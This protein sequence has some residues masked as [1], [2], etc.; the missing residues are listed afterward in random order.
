[1][2]DIEDML[3]STV[4]YIVIFTSP[5]H[6]YRANLVDCKSISQVRALLMAAFHQMW[7]DA[8]SPIDPDH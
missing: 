5:A 2:L 1:M 6:I 4:S 7:F 8:P 3:Y